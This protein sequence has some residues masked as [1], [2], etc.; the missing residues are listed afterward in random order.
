MNRQT[1]D[2]VE[3]RESPT[4][5]SSPHPS[6]RPRVAWRGGAHAP[7]KGVL[8][9]LSEPTSFYATPS[10]AQTNASSPLGWAQD[11]AHEFLDAANCSSNSISQGHP[12]LPWAQGSEVRIQSPRPMFMAMIAIGAH[13]R[14]A[15]WEQRGNQPRGSAP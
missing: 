12:S 14:L 3:G 10:V 11:W 1:V 8:A 6:P 9:G 5:A 2:D 13:G 4:L 15:L 7:P